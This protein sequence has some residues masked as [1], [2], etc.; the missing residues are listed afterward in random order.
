LADRFAGEPK[1]R[2]ELGNRCRPLAFQRQKNGATAVG[3]LIY[4]DDGD[5]PG[6]L[7]KA[8]IIKALPRRSIPSFSLV[9]RR[10]RRRG[11]V[12]CND[13]ND[14]TKTRHPEPVNGARAGEAVMKSALFSLD[15]A[16]LTHPCKLLILRESQN[17]F[18]RSAA[19][20]L[21]IR[22]CTNLRSFVVCATSG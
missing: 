11:L 5:S 8:T 6:N 4:G 7:V 10:S 19:K 17:D 15:C 9:F 12:P 13:R 18:I 21:K 22:R 2:C 20:D 16:R 14:T 1:L 3:K